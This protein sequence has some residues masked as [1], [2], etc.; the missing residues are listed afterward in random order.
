LIWLF[1]RLSLGCRN[2]DLINDLRHLD[3]EIVEEQTIGFIPI[4]FKILV[5]KKSGRK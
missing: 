5:I 1:P 3:V 4:Y 2:I